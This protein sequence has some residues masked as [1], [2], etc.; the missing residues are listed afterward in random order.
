MV[1]YFNSKDITSYYRDMYK[2]GEPQHYRAASFS[3]LKRNEKWN[4]IIVVIISFTIL[5][6]LSATQVSFEKMEPKEAHVSNIVSYSFSQVSRH[7]ADNDLSNVVGVGQEPKEPHVS[8]IV[9]DSFSQISRSN[10]T[11]QDALR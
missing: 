6:I 9:S 2:A 3:V 11:G 7:S 8:N 4:N 10:Q 1:Y 5:G